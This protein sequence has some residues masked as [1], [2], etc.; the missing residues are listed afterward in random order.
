MYMYIYIPQVMFPLQL[1][2]HTQID[3]YD[4]ECEIYEE[5]PHRRIQCLA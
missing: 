2:D 4:E 5:D 3:Q 1:V